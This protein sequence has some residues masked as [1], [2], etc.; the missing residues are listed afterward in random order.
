MM[1]ETKYLD[2]AQKLEEKI[3]EGRWTDKL[4]GVSVLSKELEVNSR[5]ISK[6][7]RAL[8]S[9]GTITIV[10]SSGTFIRRQAKTNRHGAIGV[11]GLL[12]EK[13]RAVQL[14]VVE[15]CAKQHGYHVLGIDHCNDVFREKP[16]ILLNL[17]VDG[18]IFT[19]STITPEVID[20][21][22]KARTP[23]ISVNRISDVPGVNWVDFD[24]ESAHT[25]LLEQLISLG[26]KRIAYIGF[27]PSIAEHGRRI[28][29]VYRSALEKHGLYDPNLYAFDGKMMDYYRRYGEHYCSIY[30]MEKAVQLLNSP[31]PPTA[32]VAFG[33][34]TASGVYCKLQAN[35]LSAPDDISI[36]AT[37]QNAQFTREERFFSMLAASAE[38][39]IRRAT[40]ILLE[41]IDSPRK[42]PVQELLDI[43]MII[44]R[45]VGPCKT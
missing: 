27:T 6:A 34:Q 1:F 14:D 3:Q 7:L 30:G 13:K 44:Q 32:I 23:F 5:T 8:S 37:T 31:K 25:K 22:K 42:E 12:H 36:V 2:V 43:D 17:P 35:G 26:H 29:H 20:L 41:L 21:L 11:L 16:N 28:L 40:S 4:P 10:P 24:H 19:N 9:K 38:D 18:F 39:M 45:S 15:D 33:E